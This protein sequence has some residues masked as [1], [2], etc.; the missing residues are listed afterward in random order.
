MACAAATL[1]GGSRAVRFS[2]VRARLRLEDDRDPPPGGTPGRSYRCPRPSVAA[3]HDA[4]AGGVDERQF[5]ETDD[6][7][8]D[9]A[10]LQAAADVVAE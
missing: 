5:A 2:G 7:S 9:L 6:D 3:D 8:G 10:V 4:G 1:R